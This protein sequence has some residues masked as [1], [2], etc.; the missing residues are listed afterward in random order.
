[1]EGCVPLKDTEVYLVGD[2]ESQTIYN[3]PSNFSYTHSCHRHYYI[4]GNTCVLVF[5]WYIHYKV[6]QLL[7]KEAESPFF[8]LAT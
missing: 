5:I 8:W 2:G 6:Y 1:M 7:T 3:R 4:K